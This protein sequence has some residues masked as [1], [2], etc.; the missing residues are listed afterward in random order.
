MSSTPD[1]LKPGASQHPG[2][3]DSTNAGSQG[4][5][6]GSQVDQ[7]LNQYDE[8]VGGMATPASNWPLVPSPTLPSSQV[9]LLPP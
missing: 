6:P 4:P 7:H 9:P 8:E 3:G 2:L 5:F 1:R